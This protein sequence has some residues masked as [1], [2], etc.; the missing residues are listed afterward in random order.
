M[1]II[2]RDRRIRVFRFATGKLERVYDESLAVQS[3]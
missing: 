3:Q 1:A 2:G